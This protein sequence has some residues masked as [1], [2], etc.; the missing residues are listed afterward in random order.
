M[1]SIYF[2]LS[3]IFL[4]SCSKK[5]EKTTEVPTD[6]NLLELSEAQLKSAN[7]SFDTLQLASLSSTIKVNGI[8]D[9]PPQN[10]VSVSIALGG[11][12]SSTQLLPGMHVRKGEMIATL[13]DQQY[14]QLQQDYL[15]TKARLQFVEAEFNRQKD[16]NENKASSDKVFQNAQMEYSQTKVA[17]SAFAEKLK[18]INIQPSKLTENNLS[19][20][21]PIYS[22][23]NGFVSKVNVNLGK[24]VTPSDVLFELVNPTDIHLNLQVFE[25]DINK[26]AIGQKVISYTNHEPNNKH[27]GDIIL[28]SKDLSKERSVEVHCHFDDY[29]SKLL[30][31]MYMNADIEV[32]NQNLQTLPEECVVNFEGTNYV[33]V[34]LNANQFEMQ[35]VET[36]ISENGKVEIKNAEE[37]RN[38]KIVKA[39]SYTLLMA[40]KN[41]ME[42]E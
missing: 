42:E 13:E 29:D 16:L 20:S 3:I 23:I 39:G 8:I 10:L 30:P 17:L 24:Y 12:L 14:I 37:I 25:K 6:E 36:G 1:K 38:K 5:E 35:K 7:L 26:L 2:L 41:K 32:K 11:Y 4:S 15:S 31:G 22:P 21:I 27:K 28:I 34:Q 33:F 9:V 40:L 18:L 19:R